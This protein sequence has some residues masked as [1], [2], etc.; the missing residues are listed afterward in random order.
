MNISREKRRIDFGD[1]RTQ[2]A[3]NED[4]ERAGDSGRKRVEVNMQFNKFESIAFMHKYRYTNAHTQTFC[5]HLLWINIIL[6][7][8]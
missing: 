1:Q 7:C 8:V 6:F 2:G 4:G 3:Q 5:F